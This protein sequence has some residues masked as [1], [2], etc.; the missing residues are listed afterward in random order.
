MLPLGFDDALRCEFGPDL[1]PR[2]PPVHSQPVFLLIERQIGVPPL[3]KGHNDP[4]QTQEEFKFRSEI[5]ALQNVFDIAPDMD[6]L[7]RVV[8]KG[9][10]SLE[11]GQ[12][13]G[14]IRRAQDNSVLP[15]M[16]LIPGQ[17]I[18]VERISAENFLRCV[19][20]EQVVHQK[21][22]VH[23]FFIKDRQILNLLLVREKAVDGAEDL[24]LFA[25]FCYDKKLRDEAFRKEKTGLAV[26]VDVVELA[27]EGVHIG[28]GW[29]F[30]I[31]NQLHRRVSVRQV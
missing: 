4:G 19:R 23:V 13:V 24:S 17:G 8:V 22:I 6:R 28:I 12:P 25:D 1:R 16:R 21:D 31:F 7:D 30:V 26:S 3:E 15:K 27:Q 20:V 10:V 29:Q 9:Q 2:E 5:T 11:L 18:V 14:Q